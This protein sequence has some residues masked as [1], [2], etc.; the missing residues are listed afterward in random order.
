VV[1][2][3]VG[4]QVWAVDGWRERGE[5]KKGVRIGRFDLSLLTVMRDSSASSK[6]GGLPYVGEHK[7]SQVSRLG[8]ARRNAEFG[9]E[10]WIA[11]EKVGEGADAG[12]CHCSHIRRLMSVGPD[13]HGK[14]WMGR[15]CRGH[16][17]ESLTGFERNASVRPAWSERLDE[18]PEGG[19]VHRQLSLDAW[20]DG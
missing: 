6:N 16:G 3:G 5:K 18:V 17:W 14:V 7:S 4:Y 1:E 15:R 20:E 19:R 2:V 13:N 9:D 10:V 8:A 11:G 12:A